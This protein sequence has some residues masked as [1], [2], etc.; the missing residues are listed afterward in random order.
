VHFDKRSKFHQKWLFKIKL[1]PVELGA[2]LAD[3]HLH[4][5]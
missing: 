5:A 1:I 4:G 3:M 2:T